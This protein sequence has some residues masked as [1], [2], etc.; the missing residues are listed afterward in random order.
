M[1][2]ALT[3]LMEKL[4]PLTKITEKE[5]KMTTLTA[6]DS[7]FPPPFDPILWDDKIGEL[8]DKNFIKASFLILF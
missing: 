3:W 7:S 2:A 1:G 5:I 6:K 4:I 8:K